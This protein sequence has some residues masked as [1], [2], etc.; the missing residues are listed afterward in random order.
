MK[1][2]MNIKTY[3]SIKKLI[4]YLSIVQIITL[5]VNLLIVFNTNTNI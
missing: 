5:L 4:N 3:T 2:F 1:F